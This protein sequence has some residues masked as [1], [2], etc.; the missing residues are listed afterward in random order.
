[1]N[2]QILNI[3]TVLT[4]GLAVIGC[5]KGPEA[6]ISEAKEVTETEVEYKYKAI[7]EES[8]IMWT[9]NKVVGGHSGTINVSNGVAQT[10]GNKLVGGNF[11]FDIATIK[12]TDIENPKGQTK[13]ETHLKNAD[14]F[15]VEKFP[16][17]SFEITSVEGD[18]L[19]GNL[20][21]KGIKKNITIPVKVEMT[22]DIMTITSAT[23]TIDRTD[24]NIMHNSGKLVEN[25][26]DRMIMD[27]VELKIA[28]KAKKS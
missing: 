9:A 23:F 17:A 2:K 22:E 10:K 5:K 24:W 13:L 26:G 14:F 6:E 8:M 15:D 16:N 1:M 11:I 4:L 12:N 18:K 27:D 7:P 3:F 25:L 28:I 20:T 19:S 21:M